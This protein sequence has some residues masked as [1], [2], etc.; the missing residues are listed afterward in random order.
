MEAYARQAVVSG[1]DEASACGIALQRG[2]PW[3]YLFRVTTKGACI[4]YKLDR[5]D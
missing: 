5:W 1:A 2:V 4:T 3:N